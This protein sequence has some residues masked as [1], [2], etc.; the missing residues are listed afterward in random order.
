MTNTD[1]VLNPDNNQ[2]VGPMVGAVCRQQVFVGVLTLVQHGPN[3]K[4]L[5]VDLF[6]FSFFLEMGSTVIE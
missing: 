5:T 4:A 1:E 2:I 3:T 6:L